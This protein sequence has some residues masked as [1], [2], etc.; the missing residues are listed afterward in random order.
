L[1]VLNSMSTKFSQVFK[2]IS[3]IEPSSELKDLILCGIEKEKTR[4]IKRKI[5]FSYSGM[6]G[7]FSAAVYT[8]IYLGNAFFKSEFW[9]ILSLAF[10]DAQ[11]VAGY[12]KTYLY[13]LLETL[14]TLTI[15]L[16]LIPILGLIMSV[17]FY[18]DLKNKNKHFCNNHNFKL[19]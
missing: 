18:L 13:S 3:Q 9:S 11:V 16:I 19:A 4:Q 15:V 10:S 1:I 12:W 7:S 17:G 14:P 6:V 8:L 2:N 5:Y